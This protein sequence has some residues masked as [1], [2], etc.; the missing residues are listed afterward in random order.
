MRGSKAWTRDDIGNLGDRTAVV[1]GASGGIGLETARWLAANGAH[2]VLACRD[3]DP[4]RQPAQQ[5]PGAAARRG[6]TVEVL[7][8]ANLASVRRFADRIIRDHGWIDILVNNA[9]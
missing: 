3:Q 5:M 2:V 9:G 1:T 6:A 8:L 4:G 7:D